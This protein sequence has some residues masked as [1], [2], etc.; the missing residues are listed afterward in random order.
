MVS[1]DDQNGFGSSRQ[2]ENGA[3]EPLVLTPPNREKALEWLAV[4]G[5]ARIPYSLVKPPDGWRIVVAAADI[6]RAL[7]SLDEFEQES[8]YW[9][10]KPIEDV[11]EECGEAGLISLLVAVALVFFFYVTGPFNPGVSWFDAGSAKADRIVAGEYWRLV[12]AL[13]LHD[14]ISHVLG[15]AAACFLLGIIVCQFLG[16]GTGWLLIGFTGVGG[17]M[18]TAWIYKA[19]HNSIGASTAVFGAIGI[20]GAMRAMAYFLPGTFPVKRVLVPVFIVIAML[21]F[22]GAGHNRPVDLLAHL[23]GA[24]CGLVGGCFYPSLRRYRNATAG[25]LAAVVL[26]LTIVTVSWHLALR[27]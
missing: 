24:V 26:L 12:T 21:S 5:A 18:I 3:A 27:R 9:P 22:L 17:N 13:T 10:P 7:S 14:D 23:F 2:G 16:Y 25:Q 8:R 20:L 19:G 1:H 6:N 11:V 4:L 15:N